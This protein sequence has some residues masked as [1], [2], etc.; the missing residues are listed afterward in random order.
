[1]RSLVAASGCAADV[2]N[3]EKKEFFVGLNVF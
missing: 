2:L 1:M 3:K